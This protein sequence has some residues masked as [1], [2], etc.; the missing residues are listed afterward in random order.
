MTPRAP[1]PDDTAVRPD[2]AGHRDV[3]H[4]FADQLRPAS[5]SQLQHA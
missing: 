2:E 4:G 1:L 5:R 3:N